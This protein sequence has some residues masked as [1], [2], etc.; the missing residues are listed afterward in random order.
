MAPEMERQIQRVL[1]LANDAVM[2][3]PIAAAR[4]MDALPAACRVDAALCERVRRYLDRYAQSFGVTDVSVEGAASDGATIALGNARGRTSDSAWEAS[5]HAYWQPSAYALVSLGGVAY[6]DE[7]VP[8]G[9]MVSVGFEYAQLDIGYRDHWLSPFQ[10][11]A[12]L[13]STHAQ[14][15]PSITLS[16]Y[17]PLTRLRGRYQVF[18]AEME[19]SDRIRFGNGFT[20][21]KPQLSGLHASI[22]P[23]PGWSLAGNRIMQFGG[24]ERGGRSVSDF[25]NALWDPGGFDARN[26]VTLNEEFGNQAAAW[27]SRLLVPGAVPFEV[28]F[29]YAGEDRA[30]EGNFRFGNAALSIGISF[31]QLWQRFDLTY[32][33]SEWQNAWYVHSIYQEG[34]TND[35]HV[36]GHWGAD[37]RRFGDRV[38]AQAHLLG[39]GWDAPFGGLMQVRLRTLDNEHFSSTSSR[40]FI[41]YRR[42]YDAT[43][44]YSLPWNGA[45]IGAELMAGRDVFGDS[46]S[47]LAAYMR[48]ADE[49]AVGGDGNWAFRSEDIEGTELFVDTGINAH[50]VRTIIDERLPKTWGDDMLGM[51]LAAGVRRRATVHSDLGARIELDRID[52]E[53]LLAVRAIDYRYR[54]NNPLALTA[55][56][57]AAR[58]DL[59][60]PAYG[61]YGGL[62]VQWRD[63]LPRVDLALDARFAD[64]VARDKLL[65][66]D[67]GII[68]RNDLH[69][70]IASV[71]LYL[72]YRWGTGR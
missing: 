15:L 14:T 66:S 17:A 68:L 63:I 47:R 48:F 23:M 11:S 27:T 53:Y 64:K 72:S 18:F 44:G 2:Q 61:Y 5:G 40:T 24:G 62:G 31:P 60:T 69:Y 67:P 20:S 52:G 56:L 39:V 19:H 55:F 54:F 50:R 35:G 28:Y 10:N 13:M 71:S 4:V 37:A 26:N 16:N 32:E 33:A 57:G 34:L 36:Q 70:D 6:E 22:E 38:G 1:F 12:M 29:E 65:P 9:S 43:I 7:A 21:G 49:W 42:A 30:Y 25:F 59:A 45:T 41:P 51:H 3:R 58:Y 8:S 46:F